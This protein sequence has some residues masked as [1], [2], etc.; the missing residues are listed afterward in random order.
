LVVVSSPT[1]Q[2]R[3]RR[4]SRERERERERERGGGGRVEEE[5]AAA[6]ET[7]GPSSGSGR[8]VLVTGG[9][10]Y[11]GSHAVLQL[12]TAGFRVVV[13]DSLANSSEIALRR[14]RALAGDHAR[15]L[16]FHKVINT[17]TG[18]LPV[19]SQCGRALLFIS[20]VVSRVGAE[21]DQR[22]AYVP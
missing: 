14:V 13:V 11:I 8:A 21:V 19:S 17:V 12:L 3:K 4:G 7:A 18:I 9:A 16:A 1:Q 5:M 20:R 10:G 22:D 6:K 2:I 15:N